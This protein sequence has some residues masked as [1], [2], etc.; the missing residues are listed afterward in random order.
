MEDEYILL[1]E[2]INAIDTEGVEELTKRILDLRAEDRIIIVACHDK[3]EVQLLA[4]EVITMKEGRVTGHY[5]NIRN[6]QESGTAGN[7]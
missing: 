3:E 6:I 5:E 2:P 1:D 7:A 4:D